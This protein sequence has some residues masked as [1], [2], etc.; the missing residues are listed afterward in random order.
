VFQLVKCKTKE[1]GCLE[2]CLA[3]GFMA[4]SFDEPLKFGMDVDHTCI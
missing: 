3:V 4:V 2:F 1:W